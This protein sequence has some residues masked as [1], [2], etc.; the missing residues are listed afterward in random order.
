[1]SR[2]TDNL[3]YTSTSLQQGEKFNQRRSAKKTQFK[4][5]TLQVF[6]EG[7]NTFNTFHSGWMSFDWT[8][9]YWHVHNMP[10]LFFLLTSHLKILHPQ[11][12]YSNAFTWSLRWFSKIW[13]FKM[14]CVWNIRMLYV[15]CTH[16]YYLNHNNYM[17]NLINYFPF[18][19]RF[20]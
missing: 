10:F 6:Y 9:I 5:T 17:C 1:M 18:R 2:C 20:P 12:N 16:R 7:A 13:I 11:L 15:Y 4:K 19:R 3:K 14:I 8:T